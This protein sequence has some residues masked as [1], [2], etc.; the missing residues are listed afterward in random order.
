MQQRTHKGSLPEQALATTRDQLASKPNASTLCPDSIST[1][2]KRCKR[3]ISLYR[4]V[5][6]NC[7]ANCHISTDAILYFGLQTRQHHTVKR[8]MRISKIMSA[9]AI[10]SMMGGRAS[11]KQLLTQNI[12]LLYVRQLGNQKLP[13]YC[14]NSLAAKQPEGAMISLAD[15][16]QVSE[17]CL[18]C[19]SAQK[20]QG[21]YS[22]MSSSSASGRGIAAASCSCFSYSACCSWSICTSGGARATCSTK[23]RLGSLQ[24]KSAVMNRHGQ[25]KHVQQ[26]CLTVQYSFAS[27]C[28][29]ACI[30]V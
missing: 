15:A 16:D 9:F 21:I 29:A 5:Q 3:N 30:R 11:A 27:T 7:H 28:Q 18:C 24:R 23:C 26:S 1:L 4:T 17:V 2:C 6:A 22:A 20:Q 14:N 8:K 25:C 10:V 13:I 12:N 19:P